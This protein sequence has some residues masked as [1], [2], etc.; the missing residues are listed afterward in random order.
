MFRMLQLGASKEESIT[1]NLE[2]INL[3]A[4][5][6]AQNTAMLLARFFMVEIQFKVVL[7]RKRS[8][9][10]VQQLS[11]VGTEPLLKGSSFFN[12]FA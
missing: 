6:N 8:W 1:R 7:S 11:T 12:G 10:V 2:L 5:K 3:P 9:G 4:Q